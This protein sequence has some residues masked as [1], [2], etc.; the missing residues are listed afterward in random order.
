MDKLLHRLETFR[1][2]DAQGHGFTVHAYEPMVRANP[3]S[4]E[5]HLQWEPTGKIEFKLASGEHLDLAR[6]GALTL[7]GAGLSLYRQDRAAM[8]LHGA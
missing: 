7:P 6:D 8:P 4:F 3:S 2:Q 5:P 1:A